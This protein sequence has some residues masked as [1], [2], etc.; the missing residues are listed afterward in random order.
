MNLTEIII[1]LVFTFGIIYIIYLILQDPGLMIKSVLR[2][3]KST[4]SWRLRFVSALIWIPVWIIDKIFKLNIYIDKFED[5]SRKQTMDFKAYAK[6]LEIDTNDIETITSLVNGFMESERYNNPGDNDYDLL[7]NYSIINDK[8]IIK[9]DEAVNL[10]KFYKLA[11]YI[12]YASPQNRIFH[13]KAV[14]INFKNRTDSF[15]LFANPDYSNKLVGKTFKNKKIYVEIN[16]GNNCIYFNTNIDYFKNFKFDQFIGDTVR[17]K[18]K[19][20][21]TSK[22]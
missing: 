4:E 11:E 10:T 13:V 22:H 15:F 8:L 5:A 20:L 18:Y 9:A 3:I 7:L 6:Y 21:I 16:S 19:E 1:S 17:L 14:F 12:S 2:Q